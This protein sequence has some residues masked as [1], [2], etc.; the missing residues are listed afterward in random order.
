MRARTPFFHI[1]RYR[2][3]VG[4]LA[5]DL[6]YPF[7]SPSIRRGADHQHLQLKPSEITIDTGVSMVISGFLVAKESQLATLSRVC[8]CGHK[9]NK[10]RRRGREEHH[11]SSA[12]RDTTTHQSRLVCSKSPATTST[13]SQSFGGLQGRRRGHTRQRSRLAFAHQARRAGSAPT[14]KFIG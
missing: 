1:R 8:A 2:S 10:P 9:Q 4:L 7:R 13:T 11:Q 12:E 3:P 5:G 6:R 14:K